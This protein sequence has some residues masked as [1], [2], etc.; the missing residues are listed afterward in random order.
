MRARLGLAAKALALKAARSV[1]AS[2]M[3]PE[4]GSSRRLIRRTR[5]DL[6]QPDSPTSP[7]VSPRPMVKLT[8]STAK[9]RRLPPT[10]KRFTSSP[11]SS[12][13][14]IADDS[15]RGGEEG[16]R[17]ARLGGG[18]ADQGQDRGGG[19]DAERGGR[20]GGDQRRGRGGGCEGDN[21]ALAQAAGQLEGIG[22]RPPLGIGDA[23]LLQH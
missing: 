9:S 2:S 17:R 19:G 10:S 21:E 5:V 20:L 3:L 7:T 4:V 6:P 14:L 22:L 16:R 15:R 11:I 23:H 1:P 8:S 12:R 18:R 13:A